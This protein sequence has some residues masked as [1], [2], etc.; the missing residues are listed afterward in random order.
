MDPHV[1]AA[2]GPPLRPGL[3]PPTPQARVAPSASRSPGAKPPCTL[4]AWEGSSPRG[5]PGLGGAGAAGGGGDGRRWGV[6][7]PAKSPFHCISLGTW[8][9]PLA[10]RAGRSLSRVCV[11]GSEC[12]SQWVT[13]LWTCARMCTCELMRAHAHTHMY[14]QALMHIRACIYVSACA[15]A[16]V[17]AHKHA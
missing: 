6:P 5:T 10:G 7:R 16:W 4:A 9:Q 8:G 1:R 11:R 15:H 13:E 14:S 2:G 3:P 17:H 12:V